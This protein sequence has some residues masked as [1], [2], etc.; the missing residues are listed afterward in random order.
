M[1]EDFGG[2]LEDVDDTKDEKDSSE[3]S[4]GE[5]TCVCV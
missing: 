4:E 2:S 5:D 1:S 3:E